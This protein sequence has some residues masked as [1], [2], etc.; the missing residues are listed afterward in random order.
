MAAAAPADPNVIQLGP[1]RVTPAD[2]IA[3][4]GGRTLMLSS[5]ETHLLIALALRAGR[6]LDRD[7]LSLLAPECSQAPSSGHSETPAFTSL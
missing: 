5:R 4:S 2:R 6:I 3:R 1:L 7:E